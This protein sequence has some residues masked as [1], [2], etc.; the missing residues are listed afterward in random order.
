M[1]QL[2]VFMMEVLF[3]DVIVQFF[4]VLLILLIKCY[5]LMSVVGGYVW[6]FF[7]MIICLVTLVV[8][9]NAG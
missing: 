7:V 6:A 1:L 5:M 8:S 2:E 3:K 9:Y 4:K